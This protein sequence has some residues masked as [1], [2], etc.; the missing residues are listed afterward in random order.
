MSLGEKSYQMRLAGMMWTEIANILDCAPNG[1]LGAAEKYAQSKGLRPI[2]K[3]RWKKA[4]PPVRKY[5]RK[6]DAE[7]WDKMH[8]GKGMRSPDIAKADGVDVETVR[9][10]LK[11]YREKM[12]GVE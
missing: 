7:R 6:G 3:K 12:W 8:C 4:A 11:A 1:A 5:A 2:C 10:T 9:K